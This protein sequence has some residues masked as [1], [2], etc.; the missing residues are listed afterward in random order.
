[1]ALI[2]FLPMLKTIT[3]ISWGNNRF[4]MTTLYCYLEMNALWLLEGFNDFRMMTNEG[5]TKLGTDTHIFC[6]RVMSQ[7]TTYLL[8]LGQCAAKSGLKL[9][10]LNYN[11]LWNIIK[12]G[13][14][15]WWALNS[16]LGTYNQPLPCCFKRLKLRY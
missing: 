3:D 11:D 1:M 4:G 16:H 8:S 9:Y 5:D 10:Y 14:F 6:K 7:G 12:N 2:W 15:Y 13:K